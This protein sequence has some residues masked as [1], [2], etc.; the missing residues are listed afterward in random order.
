MGDRHSFK[1]FRL[2][3]GLLKITLMILHFNTHFC[4]S[5]IVHAASLNVITK[6]KT[7]SLKKETMD[8][9][10]EMDLF[11]HSS[12]ISAEDSNNTLENGVISHEG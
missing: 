10:M 12:Y 5:L 11:F 9:E 7:L 3:I 4:H 8:L 6:Y 1:E 2:L